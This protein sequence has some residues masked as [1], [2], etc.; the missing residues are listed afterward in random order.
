MRPSSLTAAVIV[1]VAVMVAVT[2][3][4]CHLNGPGSGRKGVADVLHAARGERIF[5]NHIRGGTK[6]RGEQ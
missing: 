6:R 5:C 2:I 4:V 1:M 3:T